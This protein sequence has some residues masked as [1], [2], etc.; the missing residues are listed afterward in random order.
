[1]VVL[2]CS[3]EYSGSLAGCSKWF[4]WLQIVSLIAYISNSTS[5]LRFMS[6]EQTQSLI[7][8]KSVPVAQWLEHCAS[9]TKVVGSIPREHMY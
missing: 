3:F 7:N 4:P 1:M 8:S 5:I 9:S 6:V 2:E